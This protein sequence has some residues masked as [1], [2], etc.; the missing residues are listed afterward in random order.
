MDNNSG[1]GTNAG[2]RS[3]QGGRRGQSE[4]KHSMIGCEKGSDAPS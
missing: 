4:V 2:S 3:R 1:S